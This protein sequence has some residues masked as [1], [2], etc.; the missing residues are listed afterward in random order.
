[1]AQA[2]GPVTSTPNYSDNDYSGDWASGFVFASGQPILVELTYGTPSA[3][4]DVIHDLLCPAGQSINFNAPSS[5]HYPNVFVNR[6]RFKSQGG[7][8]A[9]VSGYVNEPRAPGI[10]AAIGSTAQTS[11]N[12]QLAQQS[13]AAPAAS[14]QFSGIPQ[15]F[16]N[17]QLIATVESDQATDQTLFLR[18]NNDAGAHYD[19]QLIYGIGSTATSAT[20]LAATAAQIGVAPGGGG[21]FG[22]VN[23]IIP[24]Y[25]AVSAGVHAFLSTWTAIGTSDETGTNGS[26]WSVGSAITSIQIFPN[27]GNLVAGNVFT[28]YGL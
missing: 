20:S 4:V 11:V 16:T 15:T 21:F 7:L 24:S 10:I 14:V 26:T 6:L 27:T 22:M 2:I 18:F 9:T 13:L 5:E 1:M 23:L 8:P 28:L 25:T 12:V 3:V 17:L 19:T